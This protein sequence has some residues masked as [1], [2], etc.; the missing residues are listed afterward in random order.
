M[1]ALG[2]MMDWLR[3]DEA[4]PMDPPGEGSANAGMARLGLV[5]EADHRQALAGELPAAWP[6]PLRI[7]RALVE[8]DDAARVQP[9]PAAAPPG[10]A[11][12]RARDKRGS[13]KLP[14]GLIERLRA[15]SRR[16]GRYQYQIVREALESHL[17]GERSPR[18]DRGG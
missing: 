9:A 15:E 11:A 16:T 5:R 6:E 2:R 10:P 1:S 18:T 13:Y 14:A 8:A 4:G 7:G 17:A 12:P 3:G